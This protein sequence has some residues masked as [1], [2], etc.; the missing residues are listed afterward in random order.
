MEV[1]TSDL[2]K[3]KREEILRLA[4]KYGARNVRIFGSVARGEDEGESD[5]D[6]LVEMEQGRSFL[7]LVGLWQDLQ[8]LLGG[9]VDVITDGGV[10]PYLRDQIYTEAIPL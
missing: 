8:E 7:D 3:S 10:S 9:E 1:G 2:L 4:A 6:F 5:V